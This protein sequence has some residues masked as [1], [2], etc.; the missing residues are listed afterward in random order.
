MLPPLHVIPTLQGDYMEKESRLNFGKMYTVEHNVRVYDFGMVD[1]KQIRQ[2]VSQWRKIIIEPDAGPAPPQPSHPNVPNS[3]YV[4]LGES[5]MDYTPPS[6]DT[7]QI[8]LRI[9]DRLSVLEW[10][11]DDW[12]YAYN[13]RTRQTGLVSIQY[14]HLY[15]TAIAR[16]DYQNTE[17]TRGYVTIQRGD[18]LR[19]IEARPDGWS[20]VWKQE[21]AE[22]GLVPSN[23]IEKQE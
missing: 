4:D 9:R 14:I 15:E 1:P 2:L 12:A 19:L 10:P 18:E 11:Y 8:A 22:T 6:G 5:N 13:T 3:I 17:E 21:T 16:Y 23:Y 7:R 20:L